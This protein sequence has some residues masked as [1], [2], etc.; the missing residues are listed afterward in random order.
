METCMLLDQDSCILYFAFHPE[1]E[2][3]WMERDRMCPT[4]SRYDEN[5]SAFTDMLQYSPFFDV[6]LM[7][8]AHTLAM[9]ASSIA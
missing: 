7:C 4:L 5:E 2:Q 8:A 3:L 6:D 1:T 9:V